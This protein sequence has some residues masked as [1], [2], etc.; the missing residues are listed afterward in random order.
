M[1]W[2]DKESV[3][4]EVKRDGSLLKYASEA[5]KNDRDIVFEAIIQFENAFVCSFPISDNDWPF[6]MASKALQNDKIFMLQMVKQDGFLY[7]FASKELGKYRNIIRTAVKK[8]PYALQFVYN[9]SKNE[10]NIFIKTI[11]KHPFV[12][13]WV[14]EILKNDRKLSIIIKCTSMNH[15]IF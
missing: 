1:N 3:L 6:Y 9:I 12:R 5:L 13:R 8:N 10:K 2:N 7:R 11:K 4:Q 15:D 14:P